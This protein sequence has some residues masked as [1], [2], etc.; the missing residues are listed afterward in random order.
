MA[1]PVTIDRVLL[2][3]RLLIRENDSHKGDYGHLLVV[4]GCERMPGASR[5]GNWCRSQVRLRVGAARAFSRA[6]REQSMEGGDLHHSLFFR[7][8]LLYLR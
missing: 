8:M 6:V 5:A 7:A 1:T 3:P 4:A 2:R